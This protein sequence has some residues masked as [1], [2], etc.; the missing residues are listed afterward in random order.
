MGTVFA[1]PSASAGL[2]AGPPPE[3]AAREPRP[4]T[5]YSA[6]TQGGTDYGVR[7]ASSRIAGDRALQGSYHRDR[8][9]LT[10][11]L[12]SDTSTS[13]VLA[14]HRTVGALTHRSPSP[15]PAATG[16]SAPSTTTTRPP[17]KQLAGGAT[18]YE[19][20][21]ELKAGA[22]YL[23][24]RTDGVGATGGQQVTILNDFGQTYYVHDFIAVSRDDFTF[25]NIRGARRSWTTASTCRIPG[26]RRPA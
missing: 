25:T 5:W 19:G 22:D 1:D 24:G 26:G 12:A 3:S 16:T 20:N 9:E 21:H 4:S 2:A 7:A 8:N 18:Y 13:P 10:A 11:P 15:S 17:R 6:R 23:D 14:A